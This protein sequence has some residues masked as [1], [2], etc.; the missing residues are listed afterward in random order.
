VTLREE[1]E[2]SETVEAGWNV[3][4][5]SRWEAILEAVGLPRPNP[6]Q[7]KPFGVGDAAI[8]IARSLSEI[9]QS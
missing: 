8:R 1:T 5:G 3:L 9:K 4:V 6:S 2:W 7:Q